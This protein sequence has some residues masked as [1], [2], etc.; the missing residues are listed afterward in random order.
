[1]GVLRILLGVMYNVLSLL[2][3]NQVYLEITVQ[4]ENRNGEMIHLRTPSLKVLPPRI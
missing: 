3:S 4:I 2:S 1:M